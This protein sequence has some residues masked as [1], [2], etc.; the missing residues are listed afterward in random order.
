MIRAFQNQAHV[1]APV[2]DDDHRV[3]A[4]TEQTETTVRPQRLTRTRDQDP[5]GV[6]TSAGVLLGSV[7]SPHQPA[8]GA[9]AAAH[10]AVVLLGGAAQLVVAADDLEADTPRVT[11]KPGRNST[12]LFVTFRIVVGY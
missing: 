9:V 6:L 1:A 10:A 4:L 3:L 12:C 5:S 2:G 11:R 8:G 7:V